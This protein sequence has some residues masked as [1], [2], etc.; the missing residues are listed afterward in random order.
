[1]NDF[2]ISLAVSVLITILRSKPERNKYRKAIFKV[3]R[4]IAL[5]FEGDLAFAE[6]V[7]D[8]PLATKDK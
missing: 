2:Y 7:K 1:M 4:E 6:M 8:L 5:Q 3:F